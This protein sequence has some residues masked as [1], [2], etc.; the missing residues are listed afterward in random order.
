M[1]GSINCFARTMTFER[2]YKCKEVIV[3]ICKPDHGTPSQITINGSYINTMDEFIYHIM[4]KT[5]QIN[6][7]MYE[8]PQRMNPANKP[9][10]SIDECGKSL[11][12]L[13]DTVMISSSSCPYNHK[14]YKIRVIFYKR[15]YEIQLFLEPVYNLE[16]N[17][18][19]KTWIDFLITK[20]EII[21][22]Y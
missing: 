13:P 22:L 11:R 21:L 9:D 16:Q 6:Y 3:V 5:K 7:Q 20:S 19:W 4:I 2:M 1:F 14:D 17:Y 18:T 10:L 15:H 8:L 12:P